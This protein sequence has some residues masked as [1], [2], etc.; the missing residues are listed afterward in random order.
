MENLPR[1]LSGAL[2]TLEYALIAIALGTILGFLVNLGSLSIWKWLRAL[3]AFYISI[4]RGTP[5][6]IQLYICFYGIPLAFGIDINAFVAGMIALSL[7]SSAYVAEIFRSGIQSVDIGQS[8]A[9]RSLGFS[10]SYTMTHVIF[11]QAF[12]NV[13]PALGNEFITLVKESSI[14]S[15]IGI[16]DITHIADLVK[17]STY[18]V[19][20]SLL[21]A[22]LIYYVITM[23]LTLVI[24]FV[25]RKLE[26]KY[27]N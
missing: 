18:K 25:E 17:A 4:F 19:F 26:K 27:A 8:E 9:A 22:A 13:I 11:P 3:S 12:K 7:N 14:V 15:L 1:F 16:N 2:I 5:S 23:S 6:L 21:I 24:K 10:R 20:E